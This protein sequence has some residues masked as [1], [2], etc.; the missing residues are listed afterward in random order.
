ME[1]NIKQMLHINGFEYTEEVEGI[2]KCTVKFCNLYNF[3]YLMLED[4]FLATIIYQCPISSILEKY[5]ITQSLVQNLFYKKS[6]ETGE[7]VD[8]DSKFYKTIVIM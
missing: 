3:K 7:L 5:N 2:L 8:V 1:K 6:R 4:V